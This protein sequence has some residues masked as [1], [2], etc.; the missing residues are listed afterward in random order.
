MLFDFVA[1]DELDAG[2]AGGGEVAVALSWSQ[3][4]ASARVRR[5]ADS[6]A[7]P[8]GQGAVA[9]DDVAAGGEGFADEG[10]GSS[11]AITSPA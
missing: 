5:G 11:G 4:A 9:G 10:V 3:R 8:D 6:G 2:V 7:E 1:Q